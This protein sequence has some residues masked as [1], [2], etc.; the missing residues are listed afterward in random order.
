MLKVRITFVDTENGRK[1]LQEAKDKL[2][3]DFNI[4]QESQV[5][6]GRGNSQYSNIYIDLENK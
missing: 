6:K 1:E 5:Y 2:S 3:K 4:L